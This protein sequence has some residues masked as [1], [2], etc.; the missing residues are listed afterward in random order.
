MPGA[1]AESPLQIVAFVEIIGIPLNGFLY[2]VDLLSNIGLARI[3]VQWVVFCAAI[4][5]LYQLTTIMR[6]QKPLRAR[7]SHFICWY[8]SLLSGWWSALLV[9]MAAASHHPYPLLAA[10]QR[11]RCSTSEELT[12]KFDAQTQTLFCSI[13]LPPISTREIG[14][15]SKD[16]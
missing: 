13:E 8:P 12:N 3:M 7:T 1:I 4:D 16:T 2:G 6:V 10:H 14:R 9:L 15:C 5:F 11:I